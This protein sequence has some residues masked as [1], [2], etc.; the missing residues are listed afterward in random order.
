MAVRRVRE[1]GEAIALARDLL[2]PSRRRVVVLVT[3]A[4][5]KAPYID[6][7]E[8]AADVGDLAEVVLMS[9]GDLT[10]AFSSVM[11]EGTQ[12]YGGAGRVYP[13]GQEWVDDLAKSPL[14]FSWGPQEGPR[15]THQLIGDVYS[16]TASTRPPIQSS[17]QA[18][19]TVSASVVG[20]PTSSQAL[21]RL[22]SGE[23]A[24][25]HT[26]RSFPTVESSRLFRKGMVVV[27]D[28]SPEARVLDISDHLPDADDSLATLPS[29]CIVPALVAEVDQDGAELLLLPGRP[30]ILDRTQVSGDPE[31]DVRDLLSAGEVVL[32]RLVRT[33]VGLTVSLRHGED[34]PTHPA[35]SVWP[36]GPAW[37]EPP[38]PASA[39]LASPAPSSAA[40]DDGESPGSPG[41]AGPD[42]DQPDPGQDGVPTELEASPT[43]PARPARPARPNPRDLDPRHRGDSPMP[44]P[45]VPFGEPAVEAPP[46]PAVLS[47]SL[48]LEAERAAS[49]E[50]SRKEAA[51]R[52]QADRLAGELDALYRQ[53]DESGREVARLEHE[54][55]R[56]KA[57]NRKARTTAAGDADEA[58]LDPEQQLRWEVKSRWVQRIPAVDKVNRPMREYELGPEFLE[59]LRHVEG[60]SRQKVVDVIVEVVTGLVDE[61]PGRDLHQLRSGSGGSDAPVVIDGLAYWRAAIQQNTASARRLHFGRDAGRLVLSR[62]C[63]HD[64]MQP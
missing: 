24:T 6:A 53:L 26:S 41:R 12:C 19:R 37:L 56:L 40:T 43:R 35:A 36:G 15:A 54:V 46:K 44:K 39:N 62:V 4:V 16:F 23:Y 60:V 33:D 14:R 30:A 42:S 55:R 3:S 47:L 22:D 57:Q 38:S 64:D 32:A 2:D 27:G 45:A 29:D 34:A 50:A 13:L 48:S 28:L 52:G 31:D 1:P 18:V 25:I 63:L 5:G 51:A 9:T 21:V 61:L 10:W 17:R 11:P 20:T 8:I 58:F 7:D 59:T 49:A